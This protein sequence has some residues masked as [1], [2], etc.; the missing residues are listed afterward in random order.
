M[1]TRVENN[2]EWKLHCIE[3]AYYNSLVY[4]WEFNADDYY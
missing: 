1:K 3:V 2:Y 4:G